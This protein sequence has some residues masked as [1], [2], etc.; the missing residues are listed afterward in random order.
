MS[1]RFADSLQAVSKLVWHIP[2]LCA[3]WKS[4]DD[5][6]RNW[7][8]HVEFY[9]R[10]KWEICASSWF[11]YK[12]LSRYTFTLN[13]KR[14][15]KSHSCSGIRTRNPG[16]RA[17]ADPLLNLTATVMYVSWIVKYKWYTLF[18]INSLT[19]LNDSKQDYPA[20]QPHCSQTW[21][22]YRVPNII[23]V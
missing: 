1:Y 19:N 2:L 9:S 3:Q 17:V 7:P 5:G 6:Q 21:L 11:Y 8:K 10:N 16:K 12:N 23:V 22:L 13:V 14:L 15:S 18:P 20:C 4:P